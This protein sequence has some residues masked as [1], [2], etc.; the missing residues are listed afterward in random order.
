MMSVGEAGVELQG[1]LEFFLGLSPI[2]VKMEPG[3]SQIAVGLSESLILLQGHESRLFHFQEGLAR[4]DTS[5]ETAEKM[6][7]GDLRIGQGKIRVE[8]DRLVEIFFVA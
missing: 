1:S 5:E 7:V 6:P 8:I 4:R 3:Q 2:Q